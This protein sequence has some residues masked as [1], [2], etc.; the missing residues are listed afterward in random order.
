MLNFAKR[1][2]H[3]ITSQNGENGI[4]DE[5]IERIGF[6]EGRRAIEFGAPTKE[7]CSNIYHL[8]DKWHK[9]YL[10]I[11]PKESGII[12]AEIT[13]ENVNEWLMKCAILSIDIDGNDYRVWQAYKGEPDIVIIEINS[14]LP[15]DRDYFNIVSGCSYKLMVELGISKGY[16]LLCHVGNCIFILNKHR[17]LFP[18]IYGDGLKNWGDYFNASWL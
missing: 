5:C 10:D 9:V 15:A 14:S 7:Y 8:N 16:F 13:P 1:Y 12:K 3:N 18:E 2:A 6:S 11:D 17:K 4:I